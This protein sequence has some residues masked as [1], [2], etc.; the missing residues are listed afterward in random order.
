MWKKRQSEV[1]MGDSALVRAL[2]FRT[3]RL[4]MNPL[5]VECSICKEVN[6]LLINEQPLA[7]T[8]LFAQSGSQFLV[9]VYC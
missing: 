8:N 9:T 6:S 4:N 7:F 5:M 2:H 3:F 1:S